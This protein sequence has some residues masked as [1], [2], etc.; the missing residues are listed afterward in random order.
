MVF[1]KN[2][3]PELSYILAKLFNKCLR[4]PYFPDCWKVSSMVPV[5]KN[6]GKRSTAKSYRPVSLLPVV[7]KVFAKLVNGKI[8]DHLEK[9]G[10]FSN[11][12]N[13]FRP[14]RSIADLLT[15]AS[16]RIDRAF[17][18]SGATR[19]VVLDLSRALECWPSSQT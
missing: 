3:E 16:D 19:A 1:L 5:F 15:V 2:C 13:G 11:F 9:C 12:Q 4:E 8:V 14:F 7:S 17:A 6:V 18:R 10:L